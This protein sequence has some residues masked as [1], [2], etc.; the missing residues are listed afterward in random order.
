MVMFDIPAELEFGPV[1]KK[2][3]CNKDLVKPLT[4]ALTNIKERGLTKELKSWD[5]CFNIRPMRGLTSMSLHSWGIAVDVC[6]A[7][8]GLGKKPKMSAEFVKCW[9]DAGFDWG[10]LW[11]RLDGMHM[12]LAHI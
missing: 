7:E 8:N 3:Y 5:G 6:A 12:Q 2:L 1:P 9:T 11:K 10:G 4:K